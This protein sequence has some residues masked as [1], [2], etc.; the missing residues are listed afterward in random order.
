MLVYTPITDDFIYLSI[1]FAQYFTDLNGYKLEIPRIATTL[2]LWL[3]MFSDI[4][5]TFFDFNLIINEFYNNLELWS[6]KVYHWAMK[7]I[8]KKLIEDFT[9]LLNAKE[10]SSIFSLDY[11]LVQFINYSLIFFIVYFSVLNI[12]TYFFR[13][14]ST[15]SG[16]TEGGIFLYAYL[17]EIEEECGQVVDVITYIIAFTLFVVW[18]FFFNIFASAIILNYIGWFF[19]IFILILIL[20]VVIPTSVFLRTGLAFVQYVRG[21]GKGTLLIFETLL[22]FVSVSVIIIRFFVQNVRF[23]FIFIGFFEYFEFISKT[24]YPLSS[25]CLPYISWNDYWAGKFDDWYW[26]Q[27]LPQLFSQFIIYIYYAGHY[28]ITYI[29]QLSIYVVLSFWIFF[30]LYTTFSLPSAE[31][32]FFFKRHGLLIK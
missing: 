1:N 7:M 27:L 22:D 14:T 8:W 28:V 19:M 30:F 23:V 5:D 26:F 31:K 20:G 9:Y 21:V 17:D 4:I 13:N 24:V 29:A 2:E 32:Y 6:L 18:F 11:R 12:Y 15:V 10:E 16:L 25:V 3:A